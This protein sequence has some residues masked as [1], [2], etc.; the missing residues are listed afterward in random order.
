MYSPSFLNIRPKEGKIREAVVA[1]I[2][3]PAAKSELSAEVDE[4]VKSCGTLPAS[5]SAILSPLL[6][7]PV[8]PGFFRLPPTPGHPQGLMGFARKVPGRLVIL[9]QGREQAE[10]GGWG[11]SR[12]RALRR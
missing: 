2:F 5:S 7:D 4:L 9:L 6:P 3:Y 12:L 8:E 11:A 1:G 10:A